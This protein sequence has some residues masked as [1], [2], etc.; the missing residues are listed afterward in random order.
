MPLGP[1]ANPG[2]LAPLGPGALRLEIAA[3]KMYP[4]DPVSQ[5]WALR[6]VLES[7]A[8]R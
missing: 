2:S 1:P 5:V 8:L 3:G 6:L 7:D 4:F